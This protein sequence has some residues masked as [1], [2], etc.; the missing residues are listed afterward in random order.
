MDSAE[1]LIEKGGCNVE[2]FQ[3]SSRQLSRQ[4]E[5]FRARVAARKVLLETA[6]TFYERLSSV[7]YSHVTIVFKKCDINIL[8]GTRPKT[9]SLQA[10]VI[11]YFIVGV[12]FGAGQT[13]VICR[14]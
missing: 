4:T 3:V 2:E 12:T 7:S 11:C 13:F 9:V 8:H 10:H 5:E 6:C 14:V 1:K